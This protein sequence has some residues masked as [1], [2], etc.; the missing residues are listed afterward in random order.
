MKVQSGP[1]FHP[2]FLMRKPLSSGWGLGQ[3]C[4]VFL[5]L[6]FCICICASTLWYCKY[7][8]NVMYCNL[9][10]T[11]CN[12]QLYN[13]V[14]KNSEVWSSR[15]VVKMA[16]NMISYRNIAKGQ[17]TQGLSAFLLYQV[18]RAKVVK[19]VKVIKCCQYHSSYSPHPVLSWF[20]FKF[21][22]H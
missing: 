16:Y 18:L 11:Q 6:Y 20:E 13:S 19:V 15:R 21:P 10:T 22:K 1:V 4:F 5:N 9:Y 7:A 3:L 8:M 2:S 17:R 12:Y 14:Q